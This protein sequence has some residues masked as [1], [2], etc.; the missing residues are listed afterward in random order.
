MARPIASL[1][2]PSCARIASS[3]ALVS[4][5]F[6]LV[7][8]LSPHQ[9]LAPRHGSASLPVGRT[10]ARHNSAEHHALG[11]L[12]QHV[13]DRFLL[14]RTIALVHSDH[15]ASGNGPL[16][17]ANPPVSRS[18]FRICC[19]H[20]VSFLTYVWRQSRLSSLAPLLTQMPI[21][22]GADPATVPTHEGDIR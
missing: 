9:K 14:G 10:L 18:Q 20:Y 11:A 1:L 7:I 21:A 2:S 15:I 5:R 16:L 12:P 13:G 8:D 4:T 19:G 17:D 3:S 22:H 6:L